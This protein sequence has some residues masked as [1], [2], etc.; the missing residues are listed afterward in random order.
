ML[1]VSDINVYYGAIHALKG[2]S[3]HVERGRLCPSSAQRRRQ[4]DD[5][6]NDFR[7]AAVPHRLHHLPGH[8]DQQNGAAQDRAYGAGPRCPKGAGFSPP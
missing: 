2:I 6:A 1:K 3:F 5:D 7:T 4:D 8:G